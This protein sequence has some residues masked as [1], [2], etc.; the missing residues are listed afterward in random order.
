MKKSIFVLSAILVFVAVIAWAFYTPNP[1]PKPFKTQISEDFDYLFN[2]IKQ[3]YPLLE[4]QK[5]ATGYDFIAEYDK[6]KA[7]IMRAKNPTEFFFLLNDVLGK[8]DNEHTHMMTKADVQYAIGIYSQKASDDYRFDIYTDLTRKALPTAY[9]TEIGMD[10][11]QE[12]RARQAKIAEINANHATPQNVQ[13]F[14]VIP[15]KLAYLSI[16]DLTHFSLIED[17]EKQQVK[18]FLQAVRDYPA[19]IIDIRTNQGGDTRYWSNFLLPAIIN[20]PLSLD[21]YSFFKQGE[22]INAYQKTRPSVTAIDRQ[23]LKNLPVSADLAGI[24]DKFAYQE[25]QPFLIKPAD[26]SIKFGGKIY[27]LVDNGVYSSAETLAIFAKYTGFA[28]LVGQPTKGDGIGTEPM[29]MLLP[30]THFAV[31]YAKQLGVA[32]NG[33]INAIAGT[34]P[35]IIV[36]NSP[37]FTLPTDAKSAKDDPVIQKVVGLIRP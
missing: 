7:H 2:T 10:A 32:P 13:T 8:L 26:D 21:L 14:D 37:D 16:K 23:K 9:Q 18:Q 29:I 3:E 22:H 5:N 33:T 15:H 1:P 4:A 20:K 11:E 30:N 28:T 6:H 31:R 17:S 12:K 25:I 27:L 36:A 24:L 19:L 35:D 34:Q